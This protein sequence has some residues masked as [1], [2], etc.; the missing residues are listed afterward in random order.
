MRTSGVLLPVSSLPGKHGIGDFGLEA[1]Q[2]VDMLKEMGSTIWQ[3]LPFNRLGYGSSPYQ[4]YSSFAGDEI[5]ISLELLQKLDL[6]P[7]IVLDFDS[8]NNRVDYEKVREFKE[9]YFR[10]AF[11]NFV[12]DEEYN[13]FIEQEW[14]YLYAVFATFKKLNQNKIWNKWKE[15]HKN[16]IKNRQYDEKIH[17]QE[18]KYE[19][20]LQYLFFKQWTDLKKY[21][22]ERGIQILGDIPIYTGLDSLDVWCNQEVYLLDEEGNPTYVAGVA[23]DYFSEEGQRW[24]NPIYNWEYLENTHFDFWV[25]RL[26]Y[27]EK[28]FDFIRIDHF[29]AFDTYWKI[30]SQ[31]ATAIEGE[32]VEAPGY[33]LLDVVTTKLPNLKIIAEDLGDLRPEVIVLRDYY[34]LK[35]MKIVQFMLDFEKQSVL[36]ESSNMIIY[37]GTH[38]NQTLQG[39]I[40]QL[41]EKMI[42][43]MNQFFNDQNYKNKNLYE[44]L[45]EYTYHTLPD[46]AIIPMQD[47]LGLDDEARLNTPGLL[48][49]LNWTWKLQNFES[50]NKIIS[51]TKPWLKESKRI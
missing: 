26:A 12:E 24:G 51:K 13:I 46:I 41:D 40:N 19:M 23:P 29:R 5:Y 20:F 32:W 39:W 3:I 38:D 9:Y 48:S 6:L 10:I 49:D 33:A 36:N 45:I 1:Y 11:S 2:F 31:C 34:N 27:T 44:N 42:R 28:M 18:I 7:N 16:W 30:P 22:N 50:F 43:R 47:L 15:E 17:I 21:A 14:V 37:T 25:K 4:A 8:S 35:G